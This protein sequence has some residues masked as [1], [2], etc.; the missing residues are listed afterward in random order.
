MKINF[1]F[2]HFSKDGKMSLPLTIEGDILHLKLTKDQ[3]FV[4]WRSDQ[5]PIVD[6]KT[7]REMDEDTLHRFLTAWLDGKEFE[8]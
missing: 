4:D 3:T 2:L 5:T 8:G 6:G 1:N 7:R